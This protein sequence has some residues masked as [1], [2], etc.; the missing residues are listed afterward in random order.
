M[1]VARLDTARGSRGSKDPAKRLAL[2]DTLL[3]EGDAA[4]CA[5]RTLEWLAAEAGAE[6]GVCALVETDGRKLRGLLGHG[7]DDS[8]VEA[9]A[10]DLGQSTDPLVVALES[11]EPVTF[12]APR[13]GTRRPQ[14]AT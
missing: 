13:E 4:S 10:V 12:E 1:G 5:L 6:R 11:R 7:V 3:A 8:E 14:P 2:T 9:M